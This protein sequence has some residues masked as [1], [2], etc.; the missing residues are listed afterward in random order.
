MRELSFHIG[1]L[2]NSREGKGFGKRATHPHLIFLGVP[3]PG[4]Q[5]VHF[6]TELNVVIYSSAVMITITKWFDV[7]FFTFFFYIL[8]MEIRL[9]HPLIYHRFVYSIVD[10]VESKLLFGSHNRSVICRVNIREIKHPY[11]QRFGKAYCHSLW[12]W[13]IS[14]EK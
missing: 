8:W 4:L 7:F 9:S 10:V 6:L 12:D 1:G 13:R 5:L 11:R 14:A 2:W 3:P